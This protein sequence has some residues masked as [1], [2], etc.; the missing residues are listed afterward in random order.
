MHRVISVQTDA[1]LESLHDLVRAQVLQVSEQE[2]G[3]S[4]L[5]FPKGTRVIQGS[6]P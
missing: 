5:C 1:S 3:L 4:S 6:S 2:P